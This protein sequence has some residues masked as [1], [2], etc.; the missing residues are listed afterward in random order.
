MGC[1]VSR[2]KVYSMVDS[3]E[4]KTVNGET[5]RKEGNDCSDALK[6]KGEIHH[7]RR[8]DQHED[9]E[10]N[11]KLPATANVEL[12]TKISELQKGNFEIN[13][14]CN[15]LQVRELY[16]DVIDGLENPIK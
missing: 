6:V 10:I 13:I 16:A 14:P 1:A 7:K 8:D 2:S 15:Q 5:P 9:M 12:L 11:T 3:C 4:V